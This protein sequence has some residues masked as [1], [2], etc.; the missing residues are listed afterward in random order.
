MAKKKS[1]KVQRK[2]AKRKLIK[3]LTANSRKGFKYA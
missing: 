3:G 2:A 1:N